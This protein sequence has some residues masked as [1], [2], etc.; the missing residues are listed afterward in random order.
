LDRCKNA[1]LY[2]RLLVGATL[3]NSPALERKPWW[4]LVGAATALWKIIAAL[5]AAAI[6]TAEDFPLMLTLELPTV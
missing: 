3:V 1:S 6:N 2:V 5:S 4:K